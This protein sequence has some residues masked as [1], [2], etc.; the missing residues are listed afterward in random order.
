[1][2][3][4]DIAGDEHAQNHR[5]A[6]GDDAG[7][8]KLGAQLLEAL[9]EARSRCNADHGHERRQPDRGQ[10]PMHGFRYPAERRMHGPQVA[11]DQ[12]GNQRPAG[13]RQGDGNT[14]DRQHQRTKKPAQQNAEAHE[15]HVGLLRRAVHITQLA[16]DPLNVAF[17]AQDEEAVAA[18]QLQPP[19]D[20]HLV[21]A[22]HNLAQEHAAAKLAHGLVFGQFLEGLAGHVLVGQHHLDNLGRQVDHLPVFDFG[23]DNAA[24]L[25]DQRVMAARHAQHITGLQHRA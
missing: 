25:Q 23:A 22:A 20:R 1:M 5:H 9:H 13:G 17:R 3:F 7:H 10:E 4:E 8:K 6:G 14:A 2:E 18:V 21:A 24:G 16:H 15:D 12:T 11:K 19:I